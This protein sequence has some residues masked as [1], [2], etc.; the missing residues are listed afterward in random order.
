MLQSL[1]KSDK[2]F[3]YLWYV[4]IWNRNNMKNQQKGGFSIYVQQPGV[5]KRIEYYYVCAENLGTFIIYSS[6][7]TV[8]RFSK[9]GPTKIRARC[10]IRGF[11]QRP[12]HSRFILG[13]LD[14]TKQKLRHRFTWQYLQPR[15]RC[16]IQTSQRLDDYRHQLQSRYVCKW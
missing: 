4:N 13:K 3:I 15:S 9:T 1:L 5:W 12:F 14:W 16:S 6:A 7:G 11:G 2:M 8:F 10:F